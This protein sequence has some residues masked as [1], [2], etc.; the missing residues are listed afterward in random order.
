MEQAHFGGEAGDYPTQARDLAYLF[1]GDII[2]DGST[3]IV[4]KCLQDSSA[5]IKHEPKGNRFQN[6]IEWEVWQT[7]KGTKFEKWFAPCIDIS[8]NGVWLIQRRIEPIPKGMFPKKVPAFFTD[9]KYQNFG[10]LGKQF[11]CCDYGTIHIEAMK[12]S[13]SKKTKKPEW[14]NED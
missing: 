8:S 9:M 3:R 12:R 11:V 7:V 13:F 4:Y 5:V 10:M 14:W 6:V 2:A 1:L